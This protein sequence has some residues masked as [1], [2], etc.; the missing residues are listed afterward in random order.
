MRFVAV[1]ENTL[2]S[3]DASEIVRFVG[4]RTVYTAD[5]I[6][7]MANHGRRQVLAVLIRQARHLSPAWPA[8]ELVAHEVMERAPQSIQRIPEKGATVDPNQ[9]DRVALLSI[10]P[11][12]SDAIFAGHKTVEFRRSRLASDIELAI[13]YAT[14]PVGRIIGWFPIVGIAE[15]TPDGLWRRFRPNGGIDRS[16]FFAY[17]D[18]AKRAYGIEIADPTATAEPVLLDALSPGLRAPQ[19]FQYLAGRHAARVVASPRLGAGRG[20]AMRAA[21]A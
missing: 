20:P 4:T 17:F 21:L 15:S 7:E 16:D 18:G 1:V 5:E 9:V 2:R 14:Q 12:Y 10:K 6:E 11:G 8:D 3:G 19:S 13:V